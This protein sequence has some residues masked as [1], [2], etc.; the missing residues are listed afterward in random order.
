MQ[1]LVETS[2]D[3]YEHRTKTYVIDA[4]TEKDAQ[5]IA[6]N[7]FNND[8]NIIGS[9]ICAR[10]IKRTYRAVFAML[11]MLIPILLSFI[12]WKDGHNTFSMKPSALSCFFAIAL[13]ITFIVRY[14]GITNVTASFIDICLIVVCVLLL[15]SFI[16]SI[17][18]S[19]TFDFFGYWQFS[20]DTKPILIIAIL[21]SLLGI[22]LVSALCL[23]LVCLFS[24]V[25]ISAQ[26]AAMGST[27]GPIYVIFS[28]VGILL[29]LSSEPTILNALPHIKSN[30]V[31]ISKK[32][33]DDFIQSGKELKCIKNRFSKSPYENNA[34]NKKDENYHEN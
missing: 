26:S 27:F 28:F 3:V 2:A 22:K 13:Y 30:V 19:T 10:S 23:S 15:S 7:R 8:F 4:K 21:F 16:Q 29:Y 18:V 25:N 20:L 34:I 31:S 11:C 6:A 9:D 12:N 1:Y 33:N 32:I 14:K 5:V 17:L 24:L